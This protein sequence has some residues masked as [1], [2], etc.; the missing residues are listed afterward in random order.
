MFEIM[1][2]EVFG[3]RNKACNSTILIEQTE[4]TFKLLGFVYEDLNL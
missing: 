1:N 3:I 2:D 4:V